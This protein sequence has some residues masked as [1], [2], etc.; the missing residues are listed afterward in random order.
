MVHVCGGGVV[1]AILAP[2]RYRKLYAPK[3]VTYVGEIQ[4]IAIDMQ[5]SEFPDRERP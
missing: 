3:E 5:R 2:N 1:D 4:D